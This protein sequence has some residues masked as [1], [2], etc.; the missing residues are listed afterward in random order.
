MSDCLACTLEEMERETAATVDE[1]LA[2]EQLWQ[3]QELPKLLAEPRKLYK[4]V[5]K[6][7]DLALN[8]RC[9]RH[10]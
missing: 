2:E 5:L 7:L 4:D 1:L 3:Q 10:E 9:S 6:D 8:G